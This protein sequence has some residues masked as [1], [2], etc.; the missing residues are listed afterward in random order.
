M[1]A[2][3]TIAKI[4]T[5]NRERIGF[6]KRR[7]SREAQ[8][9]RATLAALERGDAILGPSTLVKLSD[10]L[11]I[12]DDQYESLLAAAMVNSRQLKDSCQALLRGGAPF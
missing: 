4:L 9:S 1:T 3:D 8:V 7:L 12:P 10:A 11:Q 2:K 6:S 5:A